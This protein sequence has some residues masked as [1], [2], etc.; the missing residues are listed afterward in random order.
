VRSTALSTTPKSTFSAFVEPE[1]AARLGGEL[2]PRGAG[3]DCDLLDQQCVVAQC[4][5]HLVAQLFVGDT[6]C[7]D[8]R[9]VAAHCGLRRDRPIR[10]QVEHLCG[11][12]GVGRAQE[13]NIVNPLAQHEQAV[14]TQPHGQAR[15]GNAV[16]CGGVA[17]DGQPAFLQ[18]G[19]QRQPALA[20]FDP[21]VTLADIDLQPIRGV[22]VRSLHHPPAVARQKGGDHVGDHVHQ[23]SDAQLRAGT[24]APQVHLVRLAGSGP[25]AS[26]RYTSPGQTSKTSH[27]ERLTTP[28]TAGNH[29]RGLRAEGTAHVA[30]TGASVR[31][32]GVVESIVIVGHRHDGAASVAAHGAPPVLPQRSNRG[33]EEELQGVGA[34]FGIGQITQRQCAPNGVGAQ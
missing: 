14:E 25:M 5:A 21:L 8:H 30:C 4:R 16:V 34:L 28:A 27:R 7:D 3:F 24:Q 20:N 9:E 33:V 18:Q 11:H 26:R 13:A 2:V 19:G 31:I 6:C 12:A 22:G 15:D 17:I 10:R 29:G 23:V 32:D 1:A